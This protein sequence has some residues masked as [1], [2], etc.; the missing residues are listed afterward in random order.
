MRYSYHLPFNKNLWKLIVFFALVA[1]GGALVPFEISTRKYHLTNHI[2]LVGGIVIAGLFLIV[3]MLLKIKSHNSKINPNMVEL[4]DVLLQ[5]PVGKNGVVKAAY[6]NIASAVIIG[7]KFNGKILQVKSKNKA[8]PALYIQANGF[9]S[10]DV[11]KQFE[12]ALQQ[13][14][15]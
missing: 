11:F 13:R 15:K 4:T 2:F 12:T 1:I 6:I 7:N 9:V 5:F 8:F 3:A 10:A 14:L